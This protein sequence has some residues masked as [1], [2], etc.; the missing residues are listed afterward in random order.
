M[1][2]HLPISG[3]RKTFKALLGNAN[4]LIITALVGLDG[5]ERG[6]VRDVPSELRAAW[7]PN[8]PIISAR[9]SRRL[10]LDMALIRAIDALDIYIREAIRKPALIQ[11]RLLREK[12][13][14]AGISIFKKF[15][16]VENLVKSGDP[17]PAAIIGIMITWRNRAAHSEDDKNALSCHKELIRSN[18]STIA[19]RYCDLN[20]KLLLEGY[21]KGRAP[22]FKEIASLIRAVHEFV[23][24]I[25]TAL[26]QALDTSE[27]VRDLV[28]QAVSS[29]QR[30]G[31]ALSETRFRHVVSTWGKSAEHKER[32]VISFLRHQGISFAQTPPNGTNALIDD[33]L[34]RK[35][36]KMSPTQ[37][38]EWIGP[39]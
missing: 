37:V 20:D 7:S 14:A 3:A 5:I 31:E 16:V 24:Q 26:F 18:A 29:P 2:A 8:D 22:T 6:I 25:E 1:S 13:D 27:Y 15:L 28:C 39:G 33:N 35:L 32:A 30:N 34:V 36:I 23:G 19:S 4:H 21:E 12:I 38:K 9:R 10:L 17:I 11:S